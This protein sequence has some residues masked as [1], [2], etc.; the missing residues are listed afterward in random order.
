[1]QDA[2]GVLNLLLK[3]AWEVDDMVRRPPQQA[4][5]LIRDSYFNVLEGVMNQE[6]IL[7]PRR[8]PSPTVPADATFAEAVQNTDWFC[9]RGDN[10]P[11]YRYRRYREIV[12]YRRI[13]P[14]RAAHVDIG[15]GAGLFSWVFLDWARENGLTYN[16]IDLY[17]LDHSRAMIQLARRMREGLMR[18]IANYPP[19]RYTQDINALLQS[20]TEHHRPATDYTITFGHV[21]VQAPNAV[22]DFARVIAHIVGL[23]DAQSTCVVMAVDARR[24]A[25]QL[26]QRWIAL[27]EESARLGIR[28]QQV[29]VPETRVNDNNRAKIAQLFRR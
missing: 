17:G 13:P 19:L 26:A 4:P 25:Y 15:C 1:M 29:R 23:M 7:P 21:L 24:E 16:H 20:L 5:P 11:P 22:P 28:R 12:G 6:G 8:R 2:E 3:P 18:N 14:G 9:W 27:L 10:P